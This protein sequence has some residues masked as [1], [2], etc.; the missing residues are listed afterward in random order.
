MTRIGKKEERRN[1]MPRRP[2]LAGPKTG[3]KKDNLP[4]G[5]R[6]H[7][8]ALSGDIATRVFIPTLK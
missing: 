3:A 4:L 5:F 7:E 8:N 1:R 6:E 2:K